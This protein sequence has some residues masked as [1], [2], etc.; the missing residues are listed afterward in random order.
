MLNF[1]VIH[2]PLLNALSKAGHGSTILIADGNYPHATGAAAGVPRVYLNL[3]PGQ[4]TVDEI[5]SAVTDCIPVESAAVMV[6]EDGSAVPAHSAYRAHLGPNIPFSELGRFE[7]YDASRRPDLALL[8]A[9]GDQRPYA[10]LLLTVG[11]R[12]A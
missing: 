8:I 2:P 1:P 7:F 4:F 12:P 3:R 6:P 11:V 9:S 5:L 10:N